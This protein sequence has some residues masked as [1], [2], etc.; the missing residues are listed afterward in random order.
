MRSRW[1]PQTTQEASDL[2]WRSDRTSFWSVVAIKGW[3]LNYYSWKRVKIVWMG[4]KCCLACLMA[5][6]KA[7][8][9][10]QTVTRVTQGGLCGR[11]AHVLHL[12]TG[13]AGWRCL[14]SPIS[15][16][17]IQPVCCFHT[18][19]YYMWFISLTIADTCMCASG[20]TLPSSRSKIITVIF[21]RVAD[22][23][24]RVVPDPWSPQYPL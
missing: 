3:L 22:H 18:L 13:L 14:H 21:S 20:C 16:T 5:A 23:F 7:V 8:L 1:F 15:N 4:K 2:V 17:F 12:V 6:V 10:W 11:E 9:R 19:R 24:L